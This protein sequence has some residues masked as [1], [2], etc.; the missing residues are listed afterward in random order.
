MHILYLMHKLNEMKLYTF[1]A[2]KND[3]RET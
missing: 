2:K 3:R 1:F